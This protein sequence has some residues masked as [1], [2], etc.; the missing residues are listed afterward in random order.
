MCKFPLQD[1][2][3]GFLQTCVE[4]RSGGPAAVATVHTGAG[5]K[6]STLTRRQDILRWWF[7]SLVVRW[8]QVSPISWQHLAQL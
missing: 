8:P 1:P 6:V 4:R 5:S 2:R 7:R 3:Q